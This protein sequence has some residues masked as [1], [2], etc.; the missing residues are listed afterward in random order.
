MARNRKRQERA[1]YRAGGRVAFQRGGPKGGKAT[2]KSKE[3]APKFDYRKYQ[4]AL[5][6]VRKKGGTLTKE[7]RDNVRSYIESNPTT[8]GYLAGQRVWQGWKP[9]TAAQKE[10]D[11]VKKHGYHFLIFT[12]IPTYFIQFMLWYP[13]ITSINIYT[14]SN[15]TLNSLR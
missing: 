2:T 13:H 12:K 15:S 7:V 8:A 1:D 4:E 3:D 14:S 6:E 5:T 9:K 11:R 10:K